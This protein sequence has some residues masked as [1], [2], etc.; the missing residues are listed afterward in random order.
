M[1]RWR[2]NVQVDGLGDLSEAFAG[3]R[4]WDRSGVGDPSPGGVFRRRS[5]ADAPAAVRDRRGD[6]PPCIEHARSWWWPTS[7][8]CKDCW[9]PVLACPPAERNV[10]FASELGHLRPPLLQSF[11]DTARFRL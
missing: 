6:D 9:T 1:L 11:R 10:V 2:P 5:E 4:W 8:C 7:D 3:P